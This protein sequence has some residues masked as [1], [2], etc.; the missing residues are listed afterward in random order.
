MK[1]K[2]TKKHEAPTRLKP[3]GKDESTRMIPDRKNEP[4]RMKPDRKLK[5]VGEPARPGPMCDI[6]RPARMIPG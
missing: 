2:M 1:K 5:Q 3:D 6:V 4:T